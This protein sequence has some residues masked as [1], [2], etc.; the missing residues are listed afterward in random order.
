MQGKNGQAGKKTGEKITQ[1]KWP[2]YGKP[3]DENMDWMK[4]KKHT[5][6]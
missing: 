4:Q 6:L 1:L 2:E 5:S 3:K